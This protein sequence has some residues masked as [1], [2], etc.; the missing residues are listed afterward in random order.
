[1]ENY[2]PSK[3]PVEDFRVE[4]CSPFEKNDDTTLQTP[5][6]TSATTTKAAIGNAAI[7]TKPRKTKPGRKMEL[8]I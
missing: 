5:T 4:V 1:M 7:A 6:A 2:S 3:Q 8:D